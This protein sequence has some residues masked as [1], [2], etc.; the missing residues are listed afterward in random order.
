MKTSWVEAEWEET[1]REAMTEA[2]I[3]PLPPA[4]RLLL[5]N[6]AAQKTTLVP[7]GTASQ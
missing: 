1:D 6:L 2:K 7:G 3:Q 4:R 5:P